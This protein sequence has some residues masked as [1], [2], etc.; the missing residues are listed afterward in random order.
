MRP[1][2][3]LVPGMLNDERVW[4]DVAARLPADAAEVRIASV[5]GPDSVPA[6]AA[7]AWLRVA[8]LD[9]ATPL[10]LAGF[11]LGGYVVMEMLAQ[12]RRPIDAAALISTQCRPESPEAAQRRLQTI[13]KM[14]TDFPAV[15]EGIA[16][17]ATHDPDASLLEHLR[18]MMLQV[19][20]EMAGRQMQ[21][22]MARGDHRER[23]ATLQIPV[24]VVCGR[25]DRIT[26]CA[27]SQELASRVPGAQLRIVERSGHMLPLEQPGELAAALTAWMRSSMAPATAA[28]RAL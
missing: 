6:M 23:L 19:G 14:A 8:D 20:P 18:E 1:V 15:V 5:V 28:D 11:S 10:L 24:L 13:D 26:P 9:P 25:E 3:L 7:A 17:F 21:A 27:A 16:R 4:A 2:L 12:P 22:I